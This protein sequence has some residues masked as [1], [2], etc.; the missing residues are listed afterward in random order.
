[1][2]L[3][4]PPVSQGRI[5]SPSRNSPENYTP[6]VFA[7]HPD[8]KDIG[9]KAYEGAMERLLNAG[10]DQDRKR[11]IT[12][13]IAQYSGPDMSRATSL[14]L[15]TTRATTSAPNLWSSHTLPL[16]E[17]LGAR[18]G[19]RNRTIRTPALSLDFK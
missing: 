18:T 8:G 4:L 11:R 1:M 12:E 5:F 17:R 14:R 9:P 6:K 7:A 10:N 15:P 19:R 16:H 2:T 13:K 3:V